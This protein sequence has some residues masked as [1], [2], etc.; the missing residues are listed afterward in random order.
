MLEVR[1]VDLKY[2]SGGLK[3]WFKMGRSFT[4]SEQDW[5]PIRTVGRVFRVRN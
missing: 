1:E 5:D 4:V 3:I 2:G